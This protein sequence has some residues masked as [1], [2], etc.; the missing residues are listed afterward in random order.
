MVPYLRAANVKDGR[1][2][3]GDIMCMNFTDDEQAIFSLAPGDVLVT[4]GCGSVKEV[5]ASARWNG[6][7]PG[8]VCYQNTLLRLR[9]RQ[10]VS[11]PGFVELVARWLHRSG[12]WSSVASGTNIFHIGKGRA[13]NVPVPCPPLPDQRRIVDL[14]SSLDSYV[15]RAAAATA[16]ALQTARSVRFEV[17]EADP[18]A[19]VVRLGDLCDAGGIQIGPFGSQLHASDYVT[20]GVPTVMP[21]DMVAGRIDAGSVA[22]VSKEDWSRLPRHHL[23]VGDILLP[24]RGDLTKRALIGRDEEGWLCGTGSVRVR[25]SRADPRVVFQALSTAEVSGWLEDHAVGITMKNLNSEIVNSI[26]VRLPTG[27][28]AAVAVIESAELYSVAASQTVQEAHRVRAALLAAVLS[29]QHSIPDSYD[30]FLNEA[31]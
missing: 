6:E 10:G 29:G 16:E 13:S 14:M 25:V 5:G 22:R 3:L 30:R 19:P 4:E 2:E 9:P 7:L 24:R 27:G 18:S 17:F 21:K 20:D 15:A 11:D 8:I 12:G 1:L 26:P 28:E 31:L 23:R